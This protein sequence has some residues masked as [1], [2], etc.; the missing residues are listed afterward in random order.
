MSRKRKVLNLEEGIS[1]IRK[2]E[3]GKS[4]QA[5]AEDLRVGKTQ[6]Q[7]IIHKKTI[8]LQKWEAGK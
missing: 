8:V 4:C 1:G 6:I 2:S 5:I 3:S 7:T